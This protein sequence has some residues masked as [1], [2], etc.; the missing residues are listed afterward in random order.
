M[1]RWWPG[2]LRGNP[3]LRLASC[4]TGQQGLDY[5]TAHHPDL[6]LLD[7]HLQDGH[8]EQA[9]AELKSNP[10]TADIPVVV[11]SADASPGMIRRLLAGGALATSTKPLDLGD[12]G[13]LSIRSR[14]RLV[15]GRVLPVLTGPCRGREAQPM[16][17]SQDI[18]PQARR[19]KLVDRSACSDRCAFPAAARAGPDRQ[20]RDLD[21][22]EAG[23]EIDNC[24][25]SAQG[26]AVG[27]VGE[28]AAGEARRL[29]HAGLASAESTSRYFS[30]HRVLAL[31]RRMLPC[32][33]CPSRRVTVR[34]GGGR[35]GG[36][37]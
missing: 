13:Q 9:L 37:R 27:E 6:L 14:P 18:S 21:Q 35:G 29:D 31:V 33:P 23:S 17:T 3:V 11:L 24:P 28:C 8:G 34:A 1:S 2:Y 22:P 10:V 20:V 16:T 26:Q 4:P 32:S 25:R 19:G 15:P 12:L 7:L 5:A 30:R 36:S